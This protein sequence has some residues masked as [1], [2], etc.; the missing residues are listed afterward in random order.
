[1]KR[2]PNSTLTG[3]RK[4]NS[5]KA[6]HITRVYHNSKL[7]L[8]TPRLAKMNIIRFFL[9]L[10]HIMARCKIDPPRR[11]DFPVFENT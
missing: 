11:I 2:K 5:G 9:N 8:Y 1:M 10:L 4:K 7:M 6:C 3:R